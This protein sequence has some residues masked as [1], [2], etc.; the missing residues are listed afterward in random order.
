MLV[1]LKFFLKG[2]LTDTVKN[3]RLDILIIDETKL[4]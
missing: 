3:L 1:N 2:I 4:A